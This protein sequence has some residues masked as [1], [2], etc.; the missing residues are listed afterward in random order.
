MLS[1]VS[2]LNPVQL[3][4]RLQIA[5]AKYSSGLWSA[6]TGGAGDVEG[7]WGWSCQIGSGARVFPGALQSG[8]CRRLIDGEGSRYSWAG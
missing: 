5:I 4:T 7:A 2:H 8:L 6:D 1:G 3:W